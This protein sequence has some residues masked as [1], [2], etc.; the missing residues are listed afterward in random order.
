MKEQF[1][2]GDEENA[3]AKAVELATAAASWPRRYLGTAL[4]K[5]PRDPCTLSEI[6]R[7]H[8]L[9]SGAQVSERSKTWRYQQRGGYSSQVRRT[10][11]I[12]REGN[13]VQ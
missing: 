10:G 9:A 4:H 12:D 3:M 13:A 6:L 2:I 7:L 5:L 1:A 8:L 11:V